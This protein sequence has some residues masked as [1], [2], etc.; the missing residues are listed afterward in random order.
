MRFEVKTQ[1]DDF[2]KSSFS[3]YLAFVSLSFVII[4]G[5]LSVKLGTIAKHYEINYICKLLIIEKS[6]SNFKKL[7]KLTNKTSKQKMW[8]LCREIVK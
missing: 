4:L 3:L 6:S 8:D 2:S 5:N 7:T 1:K